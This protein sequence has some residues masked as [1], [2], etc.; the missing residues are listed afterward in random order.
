[1]LMTYSGVSAAYLKVYYKDAH[2][3]FPLEIS[4]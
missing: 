2:A 4:P 1:M 3:V